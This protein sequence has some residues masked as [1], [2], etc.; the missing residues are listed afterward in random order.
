METKNKPTFQHEINVVYNHICHRFCENG[1][2]L[3]P[4]DAYSKMCVC[5]LFQLPLIWTIF[6]GRLV[7]SIIV[8]R[9]MKIESIFGSAHRLR[10]YLKRNNILPF[11]YIDRWLNPIFEARKL[12]WFR[13]NS[14]F[15]VGTSTTGFYFENT[16]SHTSFNFN[17]DEISSIPFTGK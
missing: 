1:F 9:P 7:V 14:P 2:S 17:A 16:L 13:I 8:V 5:A 4:F 10:K 15:F 3:S 11:V 6:N 12:K